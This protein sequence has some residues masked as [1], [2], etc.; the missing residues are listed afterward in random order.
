MFRGGRTSKQIEEVASLEGDAV[1]IL[2]W[3]REQLRL[4]LVRSNPKKPV[5]RL[6]LGEHATQVRG[7]L[8]RHPPMLVEIDSSIGHMP[9]HQMHHSPA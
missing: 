1:L 8:G 7:L 5:H 2:R 6:D 4:P 3:R 9:A